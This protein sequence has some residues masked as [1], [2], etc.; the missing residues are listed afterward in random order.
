MESVSVSFSLPT[1]LS[2]QYK[3]DMLLLVHTCME[4]GFKKVKNKTKQNPPKMKQ[5]K[6]KKHVA[7]WQPV[8]SDIKNLP[9]LLYP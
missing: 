1:T 2:A 3:I 4:W 6:K 5:T 7:F 9:A 8:W